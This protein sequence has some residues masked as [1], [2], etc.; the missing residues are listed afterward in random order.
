MSVEGQR[1]VRSRRWRLAACARGLVGSFLF[2]A[3][4]V[5]DEGSVLP[6]FSIQDDGGSSRG[7]R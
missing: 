1:G 7:G 5:Q 2:E 4:A 3:S 6:V